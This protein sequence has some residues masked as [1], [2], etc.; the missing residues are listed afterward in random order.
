[1]ARG[2]IAWVTS[3]I[4]ILAGCGQPKSAAPTPSD[5]GSTATDAGDGP[6]LGFYYD[7]DLDAVLAVAPDGT[8]VIA[9]G[10]YA[11]WSLPDGSAV[12]VLLDA[13]G[14]P[15][16]LFAD[17]SL[18]LFRH[19]GANL[20]DV[21]VV[22]ED[23]THSVLRDVAAREQ[24]MGL[25]TAALVDDNHI[26]QKMKDAATAL[27]VGSCAASVLLAPFGGAP[28]ILST[29]GSLALDAIVDHVGR[30][31]LTLANDTNTWISSCLPKRGKVDLLGCAVLALE[32]GATAVDHAVQFLGTHG[33]AVSRADEE[34]YVAAPALRPVSRPARHVVT[35]DFE[36]SA[37]DGPVPL[38]LELDG[39]AST[40]SDPRGIR[41]YEWKL[42]VGNDS[43]GALT[44]GS[45]P[46]ASPLVRTAGE[47]TIILRATSVGGVT[48]TAKK[49]LVAEDED[50]PTETLDAGERDAGA[51]DAGRDGAAADGACAKGERVTVEDKVYCIVRE[52][53]YDIYGTYLYE[54]GKPLAT[55]NPDG[56]GIWQN[57][58]SIDNPIYWG[59]EVNPD[60]TPA[61]T[62]S[63][64]GARMLLLMRYEATPLDRDGNPYGNVKG[65]WILANLTIS[66]ERR[67]MYI[68]GERVK[69]Y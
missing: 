48:D 15:S 67:E 62:M 4:I 52:V 22:H 8:Q 5:A 44:I 2:S 59:I 58:N 18:F 11:V 7:A 23:G 49:I 60:G 55:L 35:A 27:K 36:I 54:G 64:F 3:L 17:G 65:D 25:Q 66:F 51:V 21:A 42:L 10:S 30:A 28:T 26:A 14:R 37:A 39:Q 13:Q 53:G 46:F 16:E 34:L 43:L 41:E 68:F 61:I 45:G 33:Q 24:E 19:H 57:H 1:M 9:E 12:S 63:E 40:T 31:N 50:T 32:K 69:S 38:D 20:M 56:T 47:H 6:S 29:C